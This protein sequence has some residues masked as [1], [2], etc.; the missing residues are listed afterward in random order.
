LF[1]VRN[2][3]RLVCLE[4]SQ[5]LESRRKNPDNA[6]I[7]AKEEVFGAGADTTDL[8]LEEGFAL[9]VWRLDLAHFEEIE[10]FPRS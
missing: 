1:H 2:R 4:S 3:P 10:R 5:D 7:A 8:V 9:V 6:I